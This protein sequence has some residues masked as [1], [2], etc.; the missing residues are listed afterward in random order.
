MVLLSHHLLPFLSIPDTCTLDTWH[1]ARD[2]DD[3][4]MLLHLREIIQRPDISALGL[5]WREGAGS[6]AD[7]GVLLNSWAGSDWG[8]GDS[9]SGSYLEKDATED[10]GAEEKAPAFTA[11]AGQEGGEDGDDGEAAEAARVAMKSARNKSDDG[12]ASML[13][14]TAA[15]WTAA[16]KGIDG[17]L[18]LLYLLDTSAFRTL[19]I[20]HQHHLGL[21]ASQSAHS[22]FT[23]AVPVSAV[24]SGGGKPI[25]GVAAAGGPGSLGLGGGNGG[26]SGRSGGPGGGGGGGGGGIG[27]VSG[28]GGG[29][30]SRRLKPLQGLGNLVSRTVGGGARSGQGNSRRPALSGGGAGGGG[31]GGLDAFD[32]DYMEAYV[33]SRGRKGGGGVG[34]VGELSVKA[35]EKLRKSGSG[36]VMPPGYGMPTGSPGGPLGLS[37]GGA[38]GKSSV[39]TGWRKD[40]WPGAASSGSPLRPAEVSLGSGSSQSRG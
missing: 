14:S 7:G 39:G 15:E 28:G 31:A 11:S 35:V 17:E 34:G 26:L 24:R 9:R 30:K 13:P 36:P 22:S 2:S 33:P 1:L 32:V 23:P 8:A 10:G 19:V 6:L 37:A 4:Q 25:G 27:A 5:M 40:S 3:E 21:K 29:G 16:R 20:K 18:A 12:S 38:G